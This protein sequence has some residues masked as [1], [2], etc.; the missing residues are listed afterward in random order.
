VKL[1]KRTKRRF[2]KCPEPTE[3]EKGKALEARFVLTLKDADKMEWSMK[4]RL[5]GKDL[6]AK[7]YYDPTDS[8]APVPPLK[9]FRMLI[10][11]AGGKRVSSADLITSYL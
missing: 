1:V 7:R 5:V 2:V 8:Y 3:S 9:L 4:A 11:S 6:K 10:A